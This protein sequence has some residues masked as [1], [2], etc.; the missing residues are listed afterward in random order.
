MDLFKSILLFF[1][2]H[3]CILEEIIMKKLYV[4]KHCGE[5]LMGD[6]DK[7]IHCGKNQ[8]IFILRHKEIISLI[9]SIL[10]IIWFIVYLIRL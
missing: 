10:L 1:N 2:S 6:S 5:L 3:V 4:C 8:R 9:V 7:C